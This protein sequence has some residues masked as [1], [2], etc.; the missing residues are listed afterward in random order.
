MSDDLVTR[1]RNIS[2]KQDGFD[3]VFTADEAADR[4]EQL[5]ATCEELESKLVKAVDALGRLVALNDDYSP[6]GGELLKDRVDRT[7]ETARTTLAA[8]SETH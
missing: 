3:A 1:L 8:V 6:F 2:R 5:A 7:W 4:I